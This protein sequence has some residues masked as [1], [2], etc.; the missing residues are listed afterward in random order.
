MKPSLILFVLLGFVGACRQP[1]TDA[2]AA[3]TRLVAVPKW[4]I[5]A[6]LLDEAPVFKD[7]KHV[8]HLSGVRFEVYMDWVRFL[9]DGTFEGHF[10]DSTNTKKFQWQVYA[11][12]NVL[13]MRDSATKTG[14]WN[15]YPRNVYADAFEMETRSTAYD[16]PRLTKV[17][18]RFVKP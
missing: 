4:Q 16:P 11:Q 2:Q 17:S 13:A 10:K 7:G 18:L 14:G 1:A 8:Q 3:A 6:I 15:V 9:P 12:Q 5:Q